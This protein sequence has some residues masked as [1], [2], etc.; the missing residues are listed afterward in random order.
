MST[1]AGLGSVILWLIS[2]GYLDGFRQSLAK[3][4]SIVMEHLLIY[5]LSDNDSDVLR[6]PN[7]TPSGSRQRE[8]TSS[9]DLKTRQY[10]RPC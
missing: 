4:Y 3:I 1:A 6:P 5:N 8:L 9:R 2:L 7:V 10:M